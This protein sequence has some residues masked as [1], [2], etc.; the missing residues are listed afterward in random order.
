[1]TNPQAGGILKM[2]HTRIHPLHSCE[3]CNLKMA[4]HRLSLP[5]GPAYELCDVCVEGFRQG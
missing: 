5:G 3:S 2:D 4:K 1:M